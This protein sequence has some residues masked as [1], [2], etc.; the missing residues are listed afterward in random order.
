[1]ISWK[2]MGSKNWCIF[3]KLYIATLGK[4]MFWKARK[5]HVPP[6]IF[7]Q[8][9][10]GWWFRFCF[11]FEA[12]TSSSHRLI[13]ISYD[14]TSGIWPIR[15]S[16]NYTPRSNGCKVFRD[17]CQKGRLYILYNGKVWKPKKVQILLPKDLV[18][19]AVGLPSFE[20]IW[21]SCTW[22]QNWVC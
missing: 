3:T 18:I 12:N 9:F 14:S 10:V 22:F 7:C 5:E 6:I 19:A 13:S 11:F 15:I 8:M 17:P 16:E 20:S 1:M 2:G 4:K 21:K